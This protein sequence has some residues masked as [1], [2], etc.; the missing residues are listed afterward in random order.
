MR[1]Q[2]DSKTKSTKSTGLNFESDL[3]HQKAAV[4]DI[5]TVFAGAEIQTAST[6]EARLKSNPLLYLSDKRFHANVAYLQ[7]QNG[8]AAKPSGSRIIDIQMETGRAKLIPTRKR[9]FVCTVI[10]VCINLC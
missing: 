8:L 10:L 7:A 5:L 9:C 2:T 6:T 3:P 4:A 1:I